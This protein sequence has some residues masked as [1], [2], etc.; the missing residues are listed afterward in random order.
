[1][2]TKVKKVISL[3]TIFRY[4]LLVI[5]LAIFG[6]ILRQNEYDKKQGVDNSPVISVL[7]E[8]VLPGD[9]IMISINS[10]STVKEITHNGNK[11][12]VVDYDG[13][14]R[15]FAAIAFD[16]KKSQHKITAQFSNGSIYEKII[17]ITPR[18][19]INKPL[20]I[21]DSLGGNTKSA[22]KSLVNNLAEENVLINN[23][24]SA[25]TA[26]WSKSFVKP[27]E[28]IYVTDQYGY[29]RNTVGYNILHKGTDFR[30]AV[31]TPVFAI[32][33]GRVVMSKSLTV[34][35]NTV[36]IDHGYGLVSLYM[37]LSK[38]N[39]KEGDSVKAGQI[40]GLSGKTGYA[41]APHLHISIK[42]NGVSIDP[43]TF[44]E[45]FNVL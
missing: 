36:I 28:K 16:E 15:A 39:V 6:L 13:K 33:S 42:V 17:N 29:N 31:G 12:G 18:E 1:M 27:L 2:T 11:L 8:I 30:A 25:N 23:V 35:G 10:T 3:N 4:I 43:V 38:L 45:F 44:F 41:E 19:K 20:G 22:G 32:N 5:F 34:Y 26:L 24:K 37:H 9:P 14:P 7:P 21:P 40:I